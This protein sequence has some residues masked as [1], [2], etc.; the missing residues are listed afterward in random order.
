MF[1]G[2]RGTK[3]IAQWLAEAPEVAVLTGAGVSSESGIPTFRDKLTG[4][5]EGYDPQELATPEGFSANPSLVW[6]WYDWRRRIVEGASPNPGHEALAALER[7][8]PRVTL[9]TQNVD[10]LHQRAGSTSVIELHGNILEFSCFARRHEAGEVERGL[11]E[12]PLCHCG[13]PL[14]PQVVWFGEAL[15]AGA[16]AE[17]NK[18]VL[19]SAVLIVAGTSGVVQ[20]AASLPYI[21]LEAGIKVIEINPC[22]TPISSQVDAF[23]EGPSGGVLPELVEM[24]AALKK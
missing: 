12:P 24:V 8:V 11:T 16:M 9:V 3:E 14:R 13:S 7:L 19:N 22:E 23:L 15:P 10:R 5:W 21:A 18:A 1:P 17:A 6:Q 2:A 20:P 4:L